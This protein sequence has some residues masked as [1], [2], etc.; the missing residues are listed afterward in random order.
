[1]FL[2]HAGF[3]GSLTTTLV[4]VLPATGLVT[5]IVYVT[6]SPA[7]TVEGDA[8]LV[9]CRFGTGTDITMVVARCE[10]PLVLNAR[11]AEVSP[12]LITD[13]GTG[14]CFASTEKL[15]MTLGDAF[16]AEDAKRL[17]VDQFGAPGSVCAVPLMEN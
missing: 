2:L 13:V 16:R 11:L 3:S 14:N 9:I 7:C 12:G 15:L 4:A 1:M 6:V 10:S 17:G 5:V 8:V